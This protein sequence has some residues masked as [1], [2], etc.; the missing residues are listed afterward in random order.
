[1][2]IRDLNRLMRHKTIFILVFFILNL[3]LSSFYLDT[4]KNANTTS[5]ALPII[6][7]FED[8][9]FRFD[10]Y[11]ELTCDKSFID[12]HYY[13]DKAP[14]P[15]FVVLPF[16]GILIQSGLISPDENGSLFGDHI[17]LLGGFLTASLP[18][19]II[20]LIVFLAIK[21]LKTNVSPVFLSTLPFYASFIFVFTGTYFPHILSGFLLLASYIYLKKEKYLIAGIFAGLSFLCEYNLAVIFMVWGVLIIIRNKSIRPVVNYS[22]GVLPSIV[23][24]LSYNYYFT[25][26]T[27]KMLYMFH[28]FDEL[29]SN[30][31]FSFPGFTSVWGLSFSWYKGLFFYS[32]FIL[33]FIIMA[34]KPAFLR[35]TRYLLTNYLIIPIIVYYFFIASYFAW[36]GGWTYGP[37]FLLGVAILLTYEGI[38]YLSQKKFSKAA[39]WILIGFGIICTFMAKATLSYSIP[40]DVA[41]P[42]LDLIIPNFFKAEFNANNILTMLFGTK[43]VYSFLI[44]VIMFVGSLVLLNFWNNKTRKFKNNL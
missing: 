12:G 26:S 10:K 20:L 39:F 21:N 31:G 9:S 2:T 24:I 42:I 15:T 23:F 33:L 38:I 19:A 22:L 29:H 17:Y 1:M 40:T 44:F 25:G 28:N 7:Y 34:F 43:P 5:R 18:F 11:H 37:R 8:G 16:F 30:Y 32:P 3:A 14:L 6:S 41:N 35:G 36:W 13:T 4:W 27:F